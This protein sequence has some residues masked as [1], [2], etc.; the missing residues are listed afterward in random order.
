MKASD[1]EWLEAL[2]FFGKEGVAAFVYT[3]LPV[4]SKEFLPSV[5]VLAVEGDFPEDESGL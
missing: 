1:E 5:R 2:S 4:I 3:S